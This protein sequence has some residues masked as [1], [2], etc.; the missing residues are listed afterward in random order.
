MKN[1]KQGIKKK[2]TWNKYRSEMTTQPKNHNLDYMTQNLGI[3]IGCL[4][5][6]SEIVTMI[7]KET[8]FSMV[9]HTTNWKSKILMH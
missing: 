7:L 6:H 2:A 5:F 8:L 4:F 1:T 3:L 9:L